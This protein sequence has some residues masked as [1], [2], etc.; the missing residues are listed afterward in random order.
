MMKTRDTPS[1][2]ARRP[3]G[4]PSQGLGERLF[5]FAIVTDTH[6]N[7]RDDV[8]EAPWPSFAKAN[9]RAVAAVDNINSASPAFVVHLGDQVNPTP[10]LP[11]YQNAVRRFDEIF[12]A[13][14]APLHTVPGN[15]DVGDKPL[16]WMPAKMV[17]T[18]FLDAYNANFGPDYR[19][20]TQAG[21]CFLLLN[22]QLFN[23]GLAQEHAQGH[24]FENELDAHKGERLFLFCHYPPF[25]LDPGEEGH[26]DNI[27]E[28][29][30]SWILELVA[31]FKVEAIFSGHVHNFFYNRVSGADFY[32]VP[33][34]AFV[35]SDFSEMFR[36]TPPGDCGRDDEAKLGWMLVDVRERGHVA[37]VVR[38]NGLGAE[39]DVD[40][41]LLLHPKSPTS[42]SAYIGVDMRQPWAEVVE[43]PYNGVVDEFARKR[44][45]ND[46]AILALS[47]LGIGR[48]RVPVQDF[49]EPATRTRMIALRAAG[50]SFCV[51]SYGIPP[52]RVDAIVAEH[53]RLLDHWEMIVALDDNPSLSDPLRAFRSGLACPL[54]LS[55]LWTAKDAKAT[56]KLSI[57]HGFQTSAPHEVG[58]LRSYETIKRLVDG[59]AF[60][61]GWDEQPGNA[62]AAIR[63]ICDEHALSAIAHLRLA[64][65]YPSTP[66]IDETENTARLLEAV[67]AA[68]RYR[69]TVYLD[70]MT[71]VDRASF[72][73]TGL[74]DR[75]FNPRATGVA[76][77]TALR[78]RG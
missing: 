67:D 72:P 22:A 2:N 75:L 63:T 9:K 44:A 77:R 5:T 61:V 15:H 6:I 51:F 41:D 29:A 60:R 50:F 62:F 57:S 21:C 19:S 71:D 54:V 27:D 69:I 43:I 32:T 53:S 17:Q 18:P 49:I 40:A 35:R 48:L 20:F 13:L 16:A 46:Y 3:D 59:V 25:I 39:R 12:S 30:R 28:P 56:F 65:D 10:A 78:G 74:V 76:L 45:R 52:S 33:S 23:S 26:Y 7:P 31:A 14:H 66:R 68:E 58:E 36:I 8:T 24:W 70:T 34:T 11:G 1:A 42:C 73:R 47:E 38:L 37:H 55:K 64:D 4:E